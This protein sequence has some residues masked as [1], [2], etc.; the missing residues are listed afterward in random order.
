MFTSCSQ[1]TNSI[2]SGI[3]N[4]NV[5]NKE[6]Q[7]S[8]SCRPVATKYATFPIVDLRRK[9]SIPLKMY[10]V[11]TSFANNVNTESL[12]RNQI[13]ALQKSSQAVYVPSSNSDLYVEPLSAKHPIPTPHFPSFNPNT[14][15]FKTSGFNNSTRTQ[16]KNIDS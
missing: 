11:D 10:K 5:P 1:I 3:Y 8:I 7:P 14:Y 9:P 15:H 12:L 4:R 13:Y 2:N 6:L 16:I